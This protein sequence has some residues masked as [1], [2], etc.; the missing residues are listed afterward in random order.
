MKRGLLFILLIVLFLNPLSFAVEDN[1]EDIK[2]QLGSLKSS[3]DN[4]TENILKQEVTIPKEFEFLLLIFVG[5]GSNINSISWEELIIFLLTVLI[6][7]IGTLGILEFTAFS[8]Q[9]VKNLIAGGL[10]L[11]AAISGVIY[12]IITI[13]FNAIDNLYIIN[14][15]GIYV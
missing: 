7:Y 6:I 13:F 3:L 10:T 15:I 8:T 12:K 11:F 9:W 5:I 2:K 4:Q 1:Q 14:R